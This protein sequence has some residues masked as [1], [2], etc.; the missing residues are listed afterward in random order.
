[1]CQE[2]VKVRLGGF[3]VFRKTLTDRKHCTM[4]TF[5]PDTRLL[6]S[7]G[8][9]DALVVCGGMGEN[10]IPCSA[11]QEMIRVVKPGMIGT[12]PVIILNVPV[13]S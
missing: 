6:L 4:S 3:S 12:V 11:I 13:L 7:S 1:M 9:Y 5:I 10:Q 2:G 8:A